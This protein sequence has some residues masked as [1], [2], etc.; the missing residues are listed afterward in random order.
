MC[1]CVCVHVCVHTC[2]CVHV[3]TYV[4]MRVCARGGGGIASYKPEGFKPEG[5]LLPTLIQFRLA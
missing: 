5:A 3:C 1:M 4:R 2:V